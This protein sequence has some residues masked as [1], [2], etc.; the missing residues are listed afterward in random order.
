VA[1]LRTAISELLQD[2]VALAD[3]SVHCRRVVVEEFGLELQAK[4]YLQLYR[5]LIDITHDPGTRN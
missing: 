5:S 1:G 2:P 4:R 3:M